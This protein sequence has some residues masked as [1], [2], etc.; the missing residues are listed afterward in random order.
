MSATQ[1]RPA[2]HGGAA[3]LAGRVVGPLALLFGLMAGLGV[4]V[5]KVFAHTFPLAQEDGI[6]RAFAARR[7]PP[8]TAVSGFLSFVGSTFVIIGVMLAVAVVFRLVFHRWRESVFLVLAVSAQALVFLLTTLVISRQRPMV[9]ELDRSPPTSSFPSGHT[10]ASTALYVGIAVVL[11]WHLRRSRARG[12]VVALLLL[13]PLSVAVARLYRGMHHPS[14]VLAAFVNG[15]LCVL[16]AARGVLFAALP[17][18][19]AR[20]LDGSRRDAAPPLP[21]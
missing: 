1:P 11:A 5:T 3:R 12:P 17:D 10:G 7:T 9:P 2:G 19:L 16:I 6:D 21:A 15:G 4:L 14:D 8:A 13:V 20:R 18:G